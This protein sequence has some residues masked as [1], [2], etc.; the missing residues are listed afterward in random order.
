[1][2]IYE[3]SLQNLTDKY[4]SVSGMLVFN[5]PVIRVIPKPVCK[6]IS[7]S[8]YFLISVYNKKDL[9]KTETEMT[10][11]K[12]KSSENKSLESLREEG[13]RI[14]PQRKQL[15]ALF[16]SLKDDEH[17]S[18]E[19][20]YKL[21]PQYNIK[22]SLATLYRGLKFLTKHNFLRELDFGEDHKHYE[23]IRSN[24]IGHHH[25]ICNKCNTACDLE[26]KELAACINKII[27]KQKDFKVSDYRFEIF[28]LCEKCGQS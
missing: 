3:K 12:N 4:R 10:D 15:L 18:A 13:H 11:K 25:L 26:D 5:Y 24:R 27:A 2:L 22:I 19:E 7:F 1:M 9:K 16:D 28:G 21:L 17:L 6:N 8:G 20:I 23:S 14:T